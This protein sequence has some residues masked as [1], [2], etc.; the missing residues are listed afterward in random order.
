MSQNDDAA[1][2]FADYC[3]IHD[4]K[5]GA[6][7]RR[8]LAYDKDGKLVEFSLWDFGPSAGDNQ[9]YHVEV[10]YAERTKG[11]WGSGANDITT[12]FLVAHWPHIRG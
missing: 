7:V 5:D 1:K 3:K 12:A 6:E 4:L 8:F 9:R 10:G 2:V 11:Q